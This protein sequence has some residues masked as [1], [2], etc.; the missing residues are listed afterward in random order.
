M[1]GHHGFYVIL[2]KITVTRVIF[3]NEPG[4]R[5]NTLFQRVGESLGFPKAHYLTMANEWFSRGKTEV[6]LLLLI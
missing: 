4:L 2:I 3:P 6:P 1:M 5:T